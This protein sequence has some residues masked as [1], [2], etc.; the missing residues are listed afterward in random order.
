MAVNC[1]GEVESSAKI[2]MIQT[3]PNFSRKLDRTHEIS[4]GQNLELKA[5]VTG[6]P[7]P[8]VSIK[9]TIIYQNLGL[10]NISYFSKRAVKDPSSNESYEF[11]RLPG[12]KMVNQ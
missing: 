7:K 11:F 9:F 5:K 6:S 12:T 3:P 8:T 4:E 2:S 10:F 1:V